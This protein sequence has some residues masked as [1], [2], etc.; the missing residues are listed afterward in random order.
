MA[1][2]DSMDEAM[3]V[4][5]ATM[6]AP[7]DAVRWIKARPYS[8]TWR[9][10]AKHFR[11]LEALERLRLVQRKVSRGETLWRPTMPSGLTALAEIQRLRKEG[12]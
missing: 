1:Y 12:E 4:A 5:M 7:H 6:V 2:A 8:S 11:A 9:K 3:R 10:S